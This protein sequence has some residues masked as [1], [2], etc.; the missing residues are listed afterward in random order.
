MSTST[1]ML[2]LAGMVGV[3]TGSVTQATLA[4]MPRPMAC[5]ALEVRVRNCLV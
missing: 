5:E 3:V 1:W 2:P 4:E